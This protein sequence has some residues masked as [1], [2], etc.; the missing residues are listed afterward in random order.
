V[1][2]ALMAGRS[3]KD[4]AFVAEVGRTTVFRWLKFDPY[5]KAVYEAWKQEHRE[6]ANGRIS[7]MIDCAVSNVAKA[8]DTGDAIISY[9]FLKDL[10]LLK[11]AKEPATEPGLVRQQIAAD[12]HEQSPLSD[13]QALANLLTQAG[14]SPEQQ[15][16]LFIQA[17]RPLRPEEPKS[18]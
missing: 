4:A 5:F 13:P 12:L 18:A 11:R 15:R 7:N 8:L 17:L 16:R 1:L 14:L 9:Q 2:E 10:G 3:I 6:S